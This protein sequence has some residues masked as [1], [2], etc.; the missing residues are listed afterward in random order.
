MKR[1]AESSSRWLRSQARGLKTLAPPATARSTVLSTSSTQRYM[2]TGELPSGFGVRLGSTGHS[3]SIINMDGPNVIMAW[4]AFPSGLGL[5]TISIAS[6][7]LVAAVP[8][9]HLSFADADDLRRLP[10]SN[11]LGHGS[12]N[13]FLYLHRQPHDRFRHHPRTLPGPRALPQAVNF[14]SGHFTCYRTIA[15][16]LDIAKPTVISDPHS[17]GPRSTGFLKA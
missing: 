14:Q 9:A 7:L 11:A 1:C 2:T 15:K 5:R 8:A 16:F 6:P 13:D 17:V 3:A 10:L 4:A 12:Q